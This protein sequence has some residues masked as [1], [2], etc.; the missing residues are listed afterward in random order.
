VLNDDGAL[1]KELL[2]GSNRNAILPFRA[3]LARSLIL[4][5][6][7]PDRALI[8]AELVADRL[9]GRPTQRQE[10]VTPHRTIFYNTGDPPP[11]LAP[12]PAEPGAS[13]APAQR[14]AAL[15]ASPFE[16]QVPPEEPFSM[17]TLGDGFARSRP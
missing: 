9:E 17:S 4:M 14:H 10:I 2:T 8:A 3:G 15:R 13:T 5:A 7:R 1:A 12:E 16:G 11:W 6:N